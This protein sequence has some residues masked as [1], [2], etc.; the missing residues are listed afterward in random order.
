MPQRPPLAVAAAL[1]CGS[2]LAFAGTAQALEAKISGHLNRAVM[3]A[4]DGERNETFFV[5]N[6]NSSSRFRFTGSEEILPG[7]KA[8][9]LWEMEFVSQNSDDVAI[10]RRDAGGEFDLNE[11]HQDI[12][13]QG[14]F[15][16]FS[17]G[18][19]A[20]AADGSAERDLSG[21]AIAIDRDAVDV[22]GDIVFAND[23]VPSG[24]RIR[25][26][27]NQF[28][29]E[30]RYDRV[31]YDTPALGPVRLAVGYGNKGEA[32][33]WEVGARA[34][35]SLPGI[36]KFAAALGYSEVGFDGNETVGG[37]A[38]FLHDLGLN[39]TLG[40]THRENDSSGLDADNFHV[41]AGYRA[42]KHAVAVNY[43]LTSFDG[44]P[45]FDTND[46]GVDD[47]GIDNS[48]F[49]GAGY[50]FKPISWAELYASVKVHMAEFETGDD[51]DNITIAMVGSRIKF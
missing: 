34:S 3:F 21:T 39:L 30:G 32:D 23:G 42:G 7:I 26:T 10:G 20:G 27:Y 50:V 19:G 11:R 37:S 35:S 17:L 28:D 49:V 29:F 8:G 45:R 14:A 1:G 4:D 12:F 25:D 43:G 51:P 15:G 44:S 33:V 31:R 36:G 6:E 22:G 47:T 2:L 38:S 41:K 48:S 46:D 5:D 16:K 13:F 40:W 24:V 9:I 18:Q